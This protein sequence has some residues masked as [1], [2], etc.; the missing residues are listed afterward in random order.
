[1]KPVLCLGLNPCFSLQTLKKVNDE[2]PE[3]GCVCARARARVCW[4]DHHLSIFTV[5]LLHSNI[6]GLKLCCCLVRGPLGPKV[7]VCV[8]A[9]ALVCVCVCVCVYVCVC[10]CVWGYAITSGCPGWKYDEWTLGAATC[11][12]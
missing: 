5:Q 12:S 8:R 9:S 4:G 6:L 3:Q 1:M 10:V 11:P 2:W 7:C